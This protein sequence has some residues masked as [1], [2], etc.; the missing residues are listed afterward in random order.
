VKAGHANE[1]RRDSGDDRVRWYILGDDG[2]ST[3][4]DAVAD[5]HT[6]NDGHACA[7]QTLRPIVMGAETISA[8]ARGCR[9]KPVARSLKAWRCR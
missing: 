5:G 4:D 9:P 3:D 2:A 1:S 8:A 7:S 6:W